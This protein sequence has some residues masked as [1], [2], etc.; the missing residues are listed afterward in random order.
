MERF[1][2]SLL[3]HCTLLLLTVSAWFAF[4]LALKL[5]S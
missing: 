2:E 4:G 1:Y 5:F 3:A